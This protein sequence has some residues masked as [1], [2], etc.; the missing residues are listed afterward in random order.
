MDVASVEAAPGADGEFA[1][2]FEV[3]FAFGLG[4]R[5]GVVWAVTA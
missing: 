3:G 2:V 5:A 4:F 1:V